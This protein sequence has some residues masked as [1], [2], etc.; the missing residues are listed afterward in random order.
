MA[1]KIKTTL[2]ACKYFILKQQFSVEPNS[3]LSKDKLQFTCC[4]SVK[5]CVKLAFN[6]SKSLFQRYYSVGKPGYTWC[7]GYYFSLLFTCMRYN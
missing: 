4:S 7:V 3:K 2:K 1:V 6:N 5:T